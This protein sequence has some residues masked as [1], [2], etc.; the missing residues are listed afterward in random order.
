M[1]D[2]MGTFVEDLTDVINRHGK[3][4]HC[5]TPDYILAIYLD[6]C[7]DAYG[8]AVRRRDKWGKVPDTTNFL[9]IRGSHLNLK[10]NE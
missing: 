5:G 9:T 6:E 4:S 2:G 3:D 7:L 8:Y 10:D 1:D